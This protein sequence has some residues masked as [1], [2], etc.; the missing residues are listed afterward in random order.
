MTDNYIQL[1]K[2]EELR[3]KIKTSEGELTGEELVFDLND[4]ELPLI[5]QEMIYKIQKN[6]EKLHNDFVVIDKREDITGK[7]AL[8]K[9]EEDKLKAYKEYLN[10]MTEAYDM[11]LGENGVKKILNGRKLG[12][13]TLDEIDELIEKQI[14]P[15]VLKSFNNIA[16]RIINKYSTSDK[17]ELK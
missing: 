11:F 10:K 2:K 8:S 13:T 17:E 16:E 15:Q 7:K 4:I 1:N 14:G 5:Y 9:N 3:L 6:K 12:W